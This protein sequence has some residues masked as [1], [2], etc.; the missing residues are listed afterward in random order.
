ME[1]KTKLATMVFVFLSLGVFQT[2]AFEQQNNVNKIAKDTYQACLSGRYTCKG[3]YYM[4]MAT[5]SVFWQSPSVG[6]S[7]PSVMIRNGR[8]ETS[9]LLIQSRVYD[10]QENQNLVGIR[11]LNSSGDQFDCVSGKLKMNDEI[12]QCSAVKE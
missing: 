1:T 10:N 11:Y 5:V 6:Q 8:N 9:T 2:F 12:Y 4:A 3:D 7:Q